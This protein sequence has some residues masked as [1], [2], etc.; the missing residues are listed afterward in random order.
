MPALIWL[1]FVQIFFMGFWQQIGEYL[2]LKKK[3][4]NDKPTQWMKSMHGMN[5]I[6]LLMFVAAVII[7]IV[8]LV[9]LPMFKK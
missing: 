9:I 3:D 7:M 8:K 4:P 2:Y 6:S 1:I 5:R